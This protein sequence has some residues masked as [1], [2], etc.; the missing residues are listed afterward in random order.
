MHDVSRSRVVIG[1]SAGTVRSSGASRR[2]APGGR[3]A[4]EATVDGLV[5]AEPALLDED[6]RRDRGH[7]LRH[8]RDAEDRVVAHRF[9]LERRLADRVDMDLAAPA[10]DRHDAGTG[11]AIDVRRHRLAQT[12]QPRLASPA[13]PPLL[14]VR[15]PWCAERGGVGSVQRWNADTSSMCEVW[16][17]RSTITMRSSVNPAAASRPTSRA[18]AAGSQLTRTSRR[19]TGRRE[20]LDRDTTE[21]RRAGSAMTRSAGTALKRSTSLR[22]MRARSP[23]RLTR[24][25]AIELAPRSTATT[26]ASRATVAAN[27]PTPA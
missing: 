2:A 1:R 14:I 4:P 26:S 27:S 25:S 8:R 16:P 20:P 12:S 21:P 5:E 23:R 10:H 22:T 15:P 3:R 17:K 7:R 13:N 24:A 19:G 11:A 6:H 9:T 18:N